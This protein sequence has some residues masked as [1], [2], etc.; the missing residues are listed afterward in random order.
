MQIEILYLDGCPTREATFDLVRDSVERLGLDADIARI[1]VDSDAQARQMEFIGSPSVRVDGVDIEPKAESNTTFGRRCRVYATDNGL[2]GTPPVAMLEAALR[3]EAYEA[4]ATS[5]AQ[6]PAQ[7]CCAPK[8]ERLR[9]RLLVAGWCPQCPA[10]K[11]FWT[12]LQ[13]KEAFDLDIIDIES[14]QGGELAEA[15]GVRAVPASIVDDHS[16]DPGPV[17]RTALEALGPGCC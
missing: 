12:N 1:H 5:G 3:G 16:P 15:L 6:I 13:Q 10:A 7:D 2:S 14:P 11:T 9:V 17:A 4:S 8:K